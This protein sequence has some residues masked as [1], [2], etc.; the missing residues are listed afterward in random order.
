MEGKFSKDWPRKVFVISAVAGALIVGGVLIANTDGQ[1]QSATTQQAS[2]ARKTASNEIY[3]VHT[4]ITAT[5]F[6]VGERAT[7]E[8]DFISNTES[9]W[10]DD[11]VKSYGGVDEPDE[12]CDYRPCDFKPLE[13]PFYFALPYGEYTAEGQPKPEEELRRV[14]WYNG[15]P[16]KDQSILKNRWIKI[17]YRDATT[18]AQWEDV[19]PF[20]ENDIGY[21]FGDDP[22]AES[23]AG[24]DISPATAQ[25][26]GIEGRGKVSW[27]FVDEQNVPSGPWREIITR[28]GIVRG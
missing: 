18:F 19:G 25:Y 15:L 26:L 11:W 10:Q 1:E 12:R 27:Q 17:T 6:W 5:V 20:G 13:N 24:L 9:Y 8:N 28:S 14:P 16:Q 2:E 7:A 22:P 4:N 23:R 21:V 3:R